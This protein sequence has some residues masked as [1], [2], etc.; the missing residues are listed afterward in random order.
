MRDI[1]V[2]LLSDVYKDVELGPSLLTI[3]GEEQAVRQ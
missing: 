2:T 3:N 1:T